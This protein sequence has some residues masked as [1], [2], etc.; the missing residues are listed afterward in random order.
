MSGPKRKIARIL[1][2]DSDDSPATKMID[3]VT[4]NASETIDTDKNSEDLTDT[5]SSN[6]TLISD[7]MRHASH[8]LR[9]RQ[10][11]RTTLPWLSV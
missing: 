3:T 2:L 6:G 10:H 1:D 5:E 8:P 9:L 11:L 4:T 7:S